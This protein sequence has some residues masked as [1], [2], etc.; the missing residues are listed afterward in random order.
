MANIAKSSDKVWETKDPQKS[1]FLAIFWF[2]RTHYNFSRSSVR[3]FDI[4]RILV[5]VVGP[6]KKSDF[7]LVALFEPRI[8]HLRRFLIYT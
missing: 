2:P 3:D 5:K 7:E 4:C 8:R 6:C 1:G